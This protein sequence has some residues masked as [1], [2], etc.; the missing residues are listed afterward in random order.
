MKSQV[1]KTKVDTAVELLLGL[2]EESS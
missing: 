2:D 1:N